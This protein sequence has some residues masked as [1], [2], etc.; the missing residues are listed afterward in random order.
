VGKAPTLTDLVLAR[1]GDERVGMQFE[2]QQWTWDEYVQACADRAA[3]LQSLDVGEPFHIGLLLDNVPEFPM[4]LGAAALCGAVIVGL[5]P[6][7]RGAE[8]IADMERTDCRVIITE[9]RHL[10]LFEGEHLP[11]KADHVYVVDQPA[12]GDALAPF[13]GSPRARP[14]AVDPSDLF[15]LIFTSGTSGN[16]KAVR[17]SHHKLTPSARLLLDSTPGQYQGS[18]GPDDV[19]YLSMPMFHSACMIQGW[20]PAVAVGARMVLRRKFSASGFLPDVRRY[21]VTYLHYVGKPLSYILATPEHPDDADNPL[22][23]AVG[24]EAA[25]LDIERFSERFACKVIDGFGSTET[26]ISVRRTP[27]T[28]RGSLGVL[29]PGGDILNPVTGEPVPPAEFDAQGRL[30]NFDEA[31]GE[32]V[33]TSGPGLFEGYYKDDEANATRMRGGMYWSG[34]LAYRN[35]RGFVFFAGRSAEWL[36]VDG[37]NFGV[38]P[39]ERI[40][41]RWPWAALV[42]VYAVPDIDVGD[43]VMA[44]I[45]PHDDSAAFDPDAF[46]AFLRDQPDMGSK[47]VPRYVRVSTAMPKT[48]TNKVLKRVM[49]KEVWETADPVW[50]RDGDRYRRLT[51]DDRASLRKAFAD[52]GRSHLLPA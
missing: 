11:V 13:R 7:R 29:P 36:R 6:T 48:E 28:P 4:L 34:D 42:A 40:L 45:Q 1:S 35:D 14:G 30:L 50:L 9:E 17:M 46:A 37:E 8:M 32:L 23:I 16:P 38:A 44:A 10:P 39:V 43:Q 22:R 47:W 24:N 27:D 3:W 31:V 19:A 15:M 12:Y 20:V 49:A 21:G 26:G 41:A 5:N 2:D 33:N 18:M 25:P 51:D 52:N